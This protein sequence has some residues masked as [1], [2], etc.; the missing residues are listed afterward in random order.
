MGAGRA[1]VPAGLHGGDLVHRAPGVDA[2]NRA[3]AAVALH[4]FGVDPVR[5][6]SCVLLERERRV[7][8]G[9]FHA[10]PTLRVHVEDTEE[11]SRADGAVPGGCSPRAFCEPDRHRAAAFSDGREAGAAVIV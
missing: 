6:P 1:G 10:H 4:A 11:E 5:N 3:E 9:G 2:R 8:V 7:C